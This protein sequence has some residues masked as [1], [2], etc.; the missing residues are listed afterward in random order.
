MWDLQ[1]FNFR[2]QDK[3]YN[4]KKWE[5]HQFDLS[6]DQN[7]DKLIL[8]RYYIFLWYL[9]NYFYLPN[10]S[11]RQLAPL[12]LTEYTLTYYKALLQYT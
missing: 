8:K 3:I 10:T 12:L 4:K 2:N 11:N 1:F 9:K 6:K 7:T 5:N